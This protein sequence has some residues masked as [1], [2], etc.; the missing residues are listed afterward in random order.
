MILQ[1]SKNLHDS[2]QRVI[3]HVPNLILFFEKG[4]SHVLQIDPKFMAIPLS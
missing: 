2:F 4:Y 3:K 1:D